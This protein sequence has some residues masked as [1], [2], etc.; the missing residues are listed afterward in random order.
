[1]ECGT[2]CMEE[3]DAAVDMQEWGGD[4]GTMEDYQSTWL[5][6][7]ISC[8]D[9]CMAPL[10]NIPALVCKGHYGEDVDLLRCYGC[11]MECGCDLEGNCEWCD[12]EQCM[13]REPAEGRF[14]QNSKKLHQRFQAAMTKLDSK[15]IIAK[16]QINDVTDL[17]QT[18]Q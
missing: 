9:A 11:G 16:K 10:Q 17:M 7:M 8:S 15:Q 3:A 4:V 6:T 1:M 12:H 2:T 18:S 5:E 13:N 14:M